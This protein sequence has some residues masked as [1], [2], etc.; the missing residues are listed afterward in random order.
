MQFHIYKEKQMIWNIL[1]RIYVESQD[2]SEALI[3]CYA[4][5]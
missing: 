3:L 5:L 2:S 1:I 4:E